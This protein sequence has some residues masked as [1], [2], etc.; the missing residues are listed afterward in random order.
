MKKKTREI[1]WKIVVGM[2][3]VATVMGMVL[4]FVGTN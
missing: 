3:A 4:P 2:V 1:I